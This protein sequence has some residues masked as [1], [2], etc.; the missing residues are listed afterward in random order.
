MMTSGREIDSLFGG[1]FCGLSRAIL[2]RAFPAP[3][4]SPAG[5]LVRVHDLAS[6]PG[7][8]RP[9]EERPEPGRRSGGPVVVAG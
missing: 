9:G 6:L 8:P 2:T 4:V 5:R 7:Y 3:P 1:Y